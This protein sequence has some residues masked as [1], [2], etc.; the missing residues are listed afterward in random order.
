MLSSKFKYLGS[1][2]LNNSNTW[3]ACFVL[4]T[5]RCSC[6]FTQAGF[7][8]SEPAP[9]MFTQDLD[10][11]MVPSSWLWF[12]PHRSLGVAFEAC[13]FL[14]TSAFVRAMRCVSYFH[15]VRALW[16]NCTLVNT[17]LFLVM[18]QLFE[19]RFWY[20]LSTQQVR[21]GLKSSVK[22]GGNYRLWR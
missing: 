8:L 2:V 12:P 21:A 18:V 6:I 10:L 3:G 9:L 22:W 4:S 11:R 20:S 19:H 13:V 5:L 7:S 17:T 15:L 14:G 1:G 16:V